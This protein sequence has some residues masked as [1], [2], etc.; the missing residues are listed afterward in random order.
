MEVIFATLLM[1]FG[2]FLIIGLICEIADI[3]YNIKGRF[4]KNDKLG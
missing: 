2:L 3:Y 1:F 4:I